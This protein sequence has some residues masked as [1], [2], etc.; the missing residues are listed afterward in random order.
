MV[1]ED[2]T[3]RGLLSLDDLRE[4]MFQ[5]DLYD[6]LVAHDLLR[7]PP[8]R[9]RVTVPFDYHVVASGLPEPGSPAAAPARR[10]RV[11]LRLRARRA[12]FQRGVCA[13]SNPRVYPR[14]RMP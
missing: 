8:A 11:L 3:F 7:Q 2:G 1:A 13:A 10:P 14:Y 5:E 4:V 12:L 9:I 6:V